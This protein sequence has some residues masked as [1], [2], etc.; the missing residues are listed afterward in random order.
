MPLVDYNPKANE[1]AVKKIF[2]STPHPTAVI[3]SVDK[4]VENTMRILRHE[5]LVEFKD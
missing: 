4:Q 2:N 1:R 5:K 3:K